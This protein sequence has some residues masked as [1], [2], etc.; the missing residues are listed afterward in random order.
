MDKFT[1]IETPIKELFII[2]TEVFTDSR[3]FFVESYNLRDFAKIEL[4]MNFVQ[5]NHSKSKKGVLRG[6]HF[7]LKHPQG[8]LVRVIKGRVFDVAVDLR[9]DSKTFTKWFGVELNEE[10]G[11]QFYIPPFFA[12][13]FLALEND[14]YFSYKCTD[15]YY[16]DDEFGFIWDDPLIN[17]KWPVDKVDEVIVSEKDHNLGSFESIK[18][19]IMKGMRWRKQ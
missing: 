9:P 17:I 19:M 2:G 6:L 8:K 13:G 1:L 7:Q 3:G 16:P 15:Y 4:N 10:N 5:D 11:L 18:E 12:H 14:T